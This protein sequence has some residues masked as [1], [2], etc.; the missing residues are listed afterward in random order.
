MTPLTKPAVN[1]MSLEGGT[2]ALF[3]EFLAR[4]FDGDAH[5]VGENPEVPFPKAVVKF[6]QNAPP[7]ALKG[8]AISMTWNAPGPVR[9]QWESLAGSRQEIC[10]TTARW[11]FWIRAELA[12]QGDTNALGIDTAQKLFGLLNNSA[13][14]QV[15]AQKGVHRLRPSTPSLVTDTGYVLRLMPCT[16]VLRWPVKSQSS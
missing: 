11:N 13:A 14:T 16:A 1:E 2:F 4:F 10:T 9:K 15:L 7:Q 8:A 3:A 5:D 12:D 6:Q